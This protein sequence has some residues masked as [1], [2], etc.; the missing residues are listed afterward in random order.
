[1]CWTLITGRNEV[2]AKVIFLHLSVILFTGG[3]L[4]QCMLGCHH[5][6]PRRPPAKET[7]YQGDPPAKETPLPR[8]PPCQGDS[9][10]GGTPSLPRETPSPCQGDP[11]RRRHPPGRRQPPGK[12]T[13]AARHTVNERPVR[14]LL[15]C[16]F[17][18]SV[19]DKHAN[20]RPIFCE[21]EL[22]PVRLFYCVCGYMPL[23]RSRSHIKVKVTS[24]LKK[25][26]HVPSNFR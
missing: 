17:V 18:V 20:S 5:P 3:G 21:G 19:G 13:P 14:I 15:E 6:L 26:I 11:P 4:P 7:P 22:P 2:V 9:P 23:I 1:M 8:R 12:Q 24:S 25:N 16:I 10:E